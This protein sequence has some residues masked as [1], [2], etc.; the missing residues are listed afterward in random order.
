LSS[1]TISPAPADQL[2][3]HVQ[4]IVPAPPV[5]ATRAPA[6]VPER[7]GERWSASCVALSL[8]PRCRPRQAARGCLQDLQPPEGRTAVGER[9]RPVLDRAERTPRHRTASA[10]RSTSAWGPPPTCRRKRLKTS[11]CCRFVAAQLLRAGQVDPRSETEMRWVGFR[12]S[13]EQGPLGAADQGCPT[14]IGPAS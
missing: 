7:E 4:P 10:S 12:S 1:T 6:T 9:R 13:S 11:I 5:T 3:D 2:V 8:Y 14:L